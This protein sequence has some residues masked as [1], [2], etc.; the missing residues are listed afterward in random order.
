MAVRLARGEKWLVVVRMFA[1]RRASSQLVHVTWLPLTAHP[2]L[3]TTS[4]L[5]DPALASCEVPEEVLEEARHAAVDGEMEQR[6]LVRLRRRR[7]RSGVLWGC[8]WG[9]VARGGVW[10]LFE[11]HELLGTDRHQVRLG[12]KAAQQNTKGAQVAG[13][14]VAL[15]RQGATLGVSNGLLGAA[16]S[17]LFFLSI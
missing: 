12:V 7:K 8:G 10:R 14:S 6:A 9:A 2:L 11:E 5:E 1:V 17:S 4:L 3:L 16:P 15:C 13:V